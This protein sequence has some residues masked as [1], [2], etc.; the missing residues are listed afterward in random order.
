M[1]GS[2]LDAVCGV[3][4]NIFDIDRHATLF[5]RQRLQPAEQFVSW[6][7]FQ[8]GEQVFGFFQR[9]CR[10][11][12]FGRDDSFRG[13]PFTMQHALH[14]PDCVG[15]N[16]M[17]GTV[18]LDLIEAKKP[19]LPQFALDDHINALVATLRGEDDGIPSLLLV[20]PSDDLFPLPALDLVD[21]IG[22]GL[23]M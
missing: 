3:L 10:E 12:R 7:Q 21:A 15:A 18:R 19:K 14:F 6:L 11:I 16:E 1:D 8:S 2:I 17:V 23:D 9:S 13:T 4:S 5:F 22:I 20:C